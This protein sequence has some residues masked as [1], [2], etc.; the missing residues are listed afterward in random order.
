MGFVLFGEYLL[1][2]VSR[3]WLIAKKRESNTKVICCTSLF[4]G[5]MILVS[6]V[7]RAHLVNIILHPSSWKPRGVIKWSW[8]LQSSLTVALSLTFGY[9]VEVH[10][11]CN[12]WGWTR[13][14]VILYMES[15]LLPSM[16]DFCDVSVLC[17]FNNMPA[18]AG[19]WDCQKRAAEQPGPA[20]GT[21]RTAHCKSWL[22]HPLAWQDE[23]LGRFS[24]VFCLCVCRT[25]SILYKAGSCIK[26]H[27]Q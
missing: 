25:I 5:W 6:D 11:T 16:C 14:L 8:S 20:G 19:S 10:C 15:R 21:D 23:A 12:V 3:V 24:T 2:L 1:G 13:E 18:A 7:H 4:K 27:E 26:S 17:T 9:V 22:L